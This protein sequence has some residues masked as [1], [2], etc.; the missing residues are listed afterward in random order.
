MRALHRWDNRPAARTPDV[1]FHVATSSAEAFGGK[2]HPYSGFSMSVCQLR[3]ESRGHIRIRSADPFEPPEIHPN[4]L[5]T[6]LDRRTAVAGLKAARAIAASE[7]MRPYI[8]REVK[9]GP[10]PVFDDELLE[11]CRNNGTTLFHP[12]GTCRMGVDA[13]AVVDPRLRVKGAQ[14]LRVIDCSVMP[15]LPSGGINAPA[16]MLGEKAVDLIREDRG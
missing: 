8:K 6:E 9:P 1:Q 11:F 15:T 13:A 7:S 2:V 14:G 3:P 16:M 10:G 5:A 12:V 4:Y